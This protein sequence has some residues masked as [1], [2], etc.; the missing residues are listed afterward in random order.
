ML[1]AF[2]ESEVT[3]GEEPQKWQTEKER[4]K[5]GEGAILDKSGEGA[6]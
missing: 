1:S 2:G 3:D 5:E 4:E 6:G